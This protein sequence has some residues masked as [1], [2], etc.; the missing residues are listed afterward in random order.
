MHVVPAIGLGYVSIS[1]K[2]MVQG[3]EPPAFDSSSTLTDALVQS[4]FAG[5]VGDFL[6]GQYGRYHHD[7]SEAVLGS[8]YTTIKDFGELSYGLSTGN[9]D[10]SDAWKFLRYNTP[11]GNLFY[12]EA[13]LNYSLHYG[14]MESLSPGSTSRMVA[15]A[16]GQ[17]NEFIFNP[18]NIW[19]YGG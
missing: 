1:L 17:G 11:F 2:S 4:G 14:M 16:E 19:S 15:R 9:K 3:K 7:F 5:F 6:G 10:A 13:A 18:K 8:A 12:T